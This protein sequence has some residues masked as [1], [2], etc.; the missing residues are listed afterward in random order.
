[1]GGFY[2]AKE[3]ELR[4]NPVAVLRAKSGV[5][6]RGEIGAQELENYLPGA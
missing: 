5:L 6:F 4:V 3:G 2:R 1:M